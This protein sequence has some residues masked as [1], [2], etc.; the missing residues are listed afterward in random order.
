MRPVASAIDLMSPDPAGVALVAL[1]D[2]LWGLQSL[3]L[4]VDAVDDRYLAQVVPILVQLAAEV[5]AVDRSAL[6]GQVN[7]AIDSALAEADRLEV[8]A[9]ARPPDLPAA[10]AQVERLHHAALEALK[11]LTGR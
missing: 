3:S 6:T 7:A 8:L 11:R 2:P 1:L 10:A 4:V 9:A 5:R